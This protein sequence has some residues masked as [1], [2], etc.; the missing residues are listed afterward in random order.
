MMASAPREAT[1]AARRTQERLRHTAG[2]RRHPAGPE[3]RRRNPHPACRSPCCGRARL[4]PNRP[5][6][7]DPPG[8][9]SGVRGDDGICL[10]KADATSCAHQAR[11]VYRIPSNNGPHRIHCHRAFLHRLP[12]WMML[13]HRYYAMQ[14]T[15]IIAPISDELEMGRH[16]PAP[17]RSVSIAQSATPNSSTCSSPRSDARRADGS[18]VRAPI[19]AQ[20]PR[21]AEC[22]TLSNCRAP[23]DT[24][25]APARGLD[26]VAGHGHSSAPTALRAGS[27]MRSQLTRTTN[28]R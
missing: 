21:A 16:R 25:P 8:I 28:L 13:S 24:T 15:D 9:G 5:S 1:V 11:S 12:L 17:K 7:R 10:P 27:G 2:S 6:T 22:G 3:S 20:T 14:Y 19:G 4:P 23:R 18:F 26:G